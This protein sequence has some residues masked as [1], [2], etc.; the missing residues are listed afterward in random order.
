[1]DSGNQEWYYSYNSPYEITPQENEL[2]KLAIREAIGFSG[3]EMRHNP[4]FFG[5]VTSVVCTPSASCVNEH[6]WCSASLHRMHS[7]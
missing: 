2:S 4:R 3:N 6:I 7:S 5:H 1:M